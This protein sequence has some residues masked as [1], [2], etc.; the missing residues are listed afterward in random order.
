M[1]KERSDDAGGL[2]RLPYRR[3]GE[4]GTGILPVGGAFGRKNDSKP[5]THDSVVIDWRGGPRRGEDRRGRRSRSCRR[6][7]PPRS[8]VPPH[9]VHQTDREGEPAENPGSGEWPGDVRCFPASRRLS[10]SSIR[11]LTICKVI[12]P[13]DSRV[14]TR[15]RRL[16]SPMLGKFL[17]S[18]AFIRQTI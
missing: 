6:K 16:E 1:E 14:V 3:C 4:C 9:S 8:R 2:L 5:E 15:R 12:R 13:A 11:E 10:I 7:T 18:G 17:S